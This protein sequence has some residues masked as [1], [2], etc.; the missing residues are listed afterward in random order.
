PDAH[1]P[2]VACVSH[3]RS[4]HPRRRVDGDLGA[5]RMSLLP[6]CPSGESI[7]AA[8]H[9]RHATQQR[10]P[11]RQAAELEERLRATARVRQGGGPASS[12]VALMP[13]QGKELT[14]AEAA[15]QAGISPSTLRRWGEEGVI[16]H[17]RGRWT[18][19]AAAHA[20]IVA[21]LRQD[22]HSLEEIR[23]AGED[24][25]LAFGYVDELFPRRKS[26]MSLEQAA[27]ETGLEPALIERIWRSLG[28]PTWMLD[29]LEE[30]D[31]D[32]LRYMASV[33]GA[34]FPLVAFLQVLRVYGTSFRQ[35][36]DAESRL[37]R[38]YVHEPLM[39]DG[40]PGMEMAE[41]MG[42]LMNQ[43]LPLATPLM[44]YVQSHSLQHAVEQTVIAKLEP[45]R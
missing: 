22:G 34:G 29:R 36:A 10:R 18:P 4:A 39:R 35:I 3:L 12:S 6:A 2:R 8:R 20:R 11:D 32:A 28:F 19:A 25:R 17:Y 41:E 7:P 26:G 21:R 1:W 45:T 33:L 42:D 38:I 40:V 31:V 43:V 23:K 9:E 44:E 5:D 24:G 37:F 16:P 30:E 13:D 27:E 14:L 15:R